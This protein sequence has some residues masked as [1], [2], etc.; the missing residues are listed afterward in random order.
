MLRQINSLR[1][2][3]LVYELYGFIT[4]DKGIEFLLSKFDE[5][6]LMICINSKEESF[7]AFIKEFQ[8]GIKYWY[9]SLSS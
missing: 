1:V 2:D 3:T 7:G 6:N 8:A 4:I 5:I 9:K